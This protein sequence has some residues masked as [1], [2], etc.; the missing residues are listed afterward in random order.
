[1]KLRVYMVFHDGLSCVFSIIK[2][3]IKIIINNYN[4]VYMPLFSIII[5]FTNVYSRIES[6]L[7]FIF[8]L[9]FFHFNVFLYIIGL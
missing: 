8:P 7:Y 5:V 4:K 2:I 3:I 6:Y 1:M 9:I